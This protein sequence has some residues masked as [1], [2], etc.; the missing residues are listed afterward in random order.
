M[1]KITFCRF[2]VGL[3]PIYK[4]IEAGWQSSI[5]P[6]T[7]NKYMN[8]ARFEFRNQL[9]RYGS[10][11]P[12]LGSKTDLMGFSKENGKKNNFVGDQNK[13]C[14]RFSFR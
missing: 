11:K 12:S 1:T 6:E 4:K 10:K 9:Q 8:I 13:P 3:I 14:Q 2:R 7:L 5:A